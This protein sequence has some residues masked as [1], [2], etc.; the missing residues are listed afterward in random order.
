MVRRRQYVDRVR[1]QP[2]ALAGHSL[3]VSQQ[4]LCRYLCGL[5]LW[6]LL[7]DLWRWSKKFRLHRRVRTPMAKRQSVE[8]DLELHLSKLD[9][10]QV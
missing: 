4:M 7:G 3:G 10:E 5:R 1:L 6:T 2:Q 8:P 9:M